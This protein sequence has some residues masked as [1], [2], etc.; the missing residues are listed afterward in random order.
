MLSFKKILQLTCAVLIGFI[1]PNAEASDIEILEIN[2]NNNNCE[3]AKRLSNE[4]LVFPAI[5]EDVRGFIKN[6]LED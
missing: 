5:K 1:A 3:E 4:L 6:C 2:Y